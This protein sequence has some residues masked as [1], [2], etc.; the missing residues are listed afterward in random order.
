MP[1][2]MADNDVKGQFKAIC[3][4]LQGPT[5]KKYWVE[6]QVRVVTFA[7]LGLEPESP[8]AI[9][10]QKCQENGVVLFTG[11]RNNEGPD[12]LDETI[13]TRNDLNSLP[14]ITLGKPGRFWP[15]RDYAERA[16]IKLLEYLTD[17]HKLLGAGRL[18][19]P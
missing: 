14:V 11:N 15:D 6:A 12:S 7:D 9:V 1:T 3:K 17:M 8:D 16:A 4:F 18:F 5:W 2:I 19:V 13:R 10:W